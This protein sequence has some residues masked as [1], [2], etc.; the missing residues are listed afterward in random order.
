[1]HAAPA[2]EPASPQRASPTFPGPVYCRIGLSLGDL[3]FS[4]K[5]EVTRRIESMMDSIE[6]SGQAEKAIAARA[7]VHRVAAGRPR[8][9]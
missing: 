9:V 2:L 4:D 6:G 3:A 8:D 7:I 1:M 5:Q